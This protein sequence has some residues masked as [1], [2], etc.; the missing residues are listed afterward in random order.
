[1]VN[2][3]PGG[4]YPAQPAVYSPPPGS[5]DASYQGSVNGAGGLAQVPSYTSASQSLPPASEA[6]QPQYSQKALL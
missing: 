6:Q 5:T 3:G 1:M 2:S 4:A